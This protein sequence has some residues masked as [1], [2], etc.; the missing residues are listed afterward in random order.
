MAFEFELGTVLD[1]YGVVLVA[2]GCFIALGIVFFFITNKKYPQV[3][4]D[5]IEGKRLELQTM[6]LMGDKVVP[7]NLLRILLEGNKLIGFNIHD[8]DYYYSGNKRRYLAT[9]HGEDLVPLKIKDDMIQLEELG[10][11]RE[12]AIRYINTIDSVAQDLN[13][14]NPLILALISVIP[15]GVLVILTGI[16][17]YLILNNALPQML[18]VSSKMQASQLEMSEN[19]KHVADAQIILAQKFPDAYNTTMHNNTIYLPG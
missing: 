6:R 12:I 2:L 14:Q 3:Y 18:A 1:Q 16:M 7:N 17:F 9:K 5:V 19:L 15:I 10:T 4:F 11:G 13:K 8:F